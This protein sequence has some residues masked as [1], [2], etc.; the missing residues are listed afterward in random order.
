VISLEQKGENKNLL[1]DSEIT[2]S[3]LL[4]IFSFYFF[5]SMFLP[6]WRDEVKPHCS[7]DPSLRVGRRGEK[8]NGSVQLSLF[9]YFSLLL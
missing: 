3:V 9:F 2:Q 4:F 1:F 8:G 7:D 5:S 6:L